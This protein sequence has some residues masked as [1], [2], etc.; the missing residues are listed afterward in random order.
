MS[1]SSGWPSTGGQSARSAR[2]L[3]K[4]RAVLRRI[5]LAGLI[6]ILALTVVCEGLV[7]L[8][9]LAI[10]ESLLKFLART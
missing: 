2:E 9:L 6:P 5:L 3:G 8:A 1:E 4:T 7:I 10:A